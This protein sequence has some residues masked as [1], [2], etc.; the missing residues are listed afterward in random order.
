MA[1]LACAQFELLGHRGNSK[2]DS[3]SSIANSSHV[4]LIMTLA[5]METHMHSYLAASRWAQTSSWHVG[6]FM[7]QIR[8]WF[9]SVSS[10]VSVTRQP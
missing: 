2:Q 5:G 1:L 3:V 10:E 7:P 6:A 4:F 9:P 8:T